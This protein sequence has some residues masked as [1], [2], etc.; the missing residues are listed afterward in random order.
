[1][2]CWLVVC[3]SACMYV[4]Y[5]CKLGFCVSLFD[6][7]AVDRCCQYECKWL[8]GVEWR[9]M[10]QAVG[11]RPLLTHPTAVLVIVRLAVRVLYRR[12]QAVVW[13]DLQLG[14]PEH[15]PQ[16]LAQLYCYKTHRTLNSASAVIFA[17]GDYDFCFAQWLVIPADLR[18]TSLQCW[19]WWW[20][21]L[22]LLL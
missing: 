15:M 20:W 12:K 11:R 22:L 13:S 8:P 17:L 5:Y 1:M 21:L 4:D 3:T 2:F 18:N 7:F 9:V 16:R 14:P 10:C 19:W 6:F